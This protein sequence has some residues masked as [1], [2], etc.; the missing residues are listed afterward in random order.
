MLYQNGRCQPSWGVMRNAACKQ[1]MELW[2]EQDINLLGHWGLEFAAKTNTHDP[3]ISYACTW[4]HSVNSA[5]LPCNYPYVLLWSSSGLRSPTWP[6]PNILHTFPDLN[7][8]LPSPS[9]P[10]RGNLTLHWTFVIFL[11]ACWVEC[12]ICYFYIHHPRFWICLMMNIQC[13][14][15]YSPFPDCSTINRF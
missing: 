2:C 13:Y 5:R 8:I 7:Q 3:P 11:P 14:I 6:R 12:A 15:I 1:F 4:L 9:F 10:T